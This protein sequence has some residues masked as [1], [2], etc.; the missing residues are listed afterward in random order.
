[1]PQRG[2]DHRDGRGARLVVAGC[3]RATHRD[4]CAEHAEEVAADGREVDPECLGPV[5]NRLWP[6]IDRDRTCDVLKRTCL[7]SEMIEVLRRERQRAHALARLSPED[8]DALLIKDGERAAQDCTG[9]GKDRNGEP[10]AACEHEDN[11]GGRLRL[12]HHSAESGPNVVLSV[13]A[14][15]PAKSRAH[16]RILGWRSQPRLVHLSE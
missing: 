14:A 9:S 3:K 16:R 10:D 12:A 15:R 6:R 7:V 4:A 11:R 13:P 2:A 8:D 1:V 5:A